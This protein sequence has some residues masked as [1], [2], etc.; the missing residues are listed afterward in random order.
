[1]PQISAVREAVASL[2]CPDF[3]DSAWLGPFE[4]LTGAAYGLLT[5]GRHGF[6]QRDQRR[7]Q[8]HTHVR[9]R[10]AS[11]VAESAF[12]QEPAD[13]A[14]F[15]DWVSAFYF[16]SAVHRMVWAA[17]R[18]VVTLATLACPCGHPAELQD[19]VVYGFAEYWNAASRR[20]EH[21]A[22]EHQQ[23]LEHAHVLL[24]QIVPIKFTRHEMTF[25]P[26]AVFTMWQHDLRRKQLPHGAPHRNGGV[27]WSTAAPGLQFQTACAGFALACRAFNELVAWHYEARES[28]LAALG[29]RA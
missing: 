2:P 16:N 15:D 22:A 29:E 21:V 19:T 8:Y 3:G 13:R 23:D 27:S 20:V 9:E 25:N 6:S 28:E 4:L 14:V 7:Y 5:A 1:M 11:L 12:A 18:M 26:D 24:Q 17:E 10:I